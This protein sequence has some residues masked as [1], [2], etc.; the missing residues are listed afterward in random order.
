MVL[1]PRWCLCPVEHGR[2][3]PSQ[4]WIAKKSGLVGRP[5]DPDLLQKITTKRPC[6][7]SGFA[8]KR[9]LEQKSHKKKTHTSNWIAAGTQYSDILQLVDL[10][11][12][13]EILSTSLVSLLGPLKCFHLLKVDTYFAKPSLNALLSWWVS[14]IVGQM[15]TLPNPP[16]HVGHGDAIY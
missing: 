13:R 7:Q 6:T 1:L 5:T 15:N 11:G 4:I 14:G 2:I 3:K 16:F 8:K 9:T 10:R 12:T